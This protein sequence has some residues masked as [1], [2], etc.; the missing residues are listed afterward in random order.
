LLNKAMGELND[1]V[2][3]LEKQVEEDE[4]D[5]LDLLEL[6]TFVAELDVRKS[7]AERF[8][9]VAISG[10]RFYS[11]VSNLTL[12]DEPLKQCPHKLGHLARYLAAARLHRP[13][14]KQAKAGIAA[15]E[16]QVRLSRS[17]LFPDLGLGLS[18]GLSA[19]PE[20]ADQI[21]PYVS[22][23]GNYFHYGAAIVFQWRLD[24]APAVARIAYA[25]AQLQEVMALDRKALGG[26][27]AEVEGAY[28]EV[29]D[30]QKRLAAYRK[31]EGYS[32]KWFVTVQQGIDIGTMED[33]ELLDPAKRYAE[34]RYNVLKATM[35]YNMAMAKLA[36]ATGW[37]AIA[38]GG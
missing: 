24:F 30:W 25:Q 35:E 32:R 38:P 12:A 13:E 3:R 34:H 17:K 10:L 1:E 23:G 11:G 7:E 16:A 6:Q 14:V 21:N 22:D 26:V 2:V 15:R 37:D 29:V 20:V 36:K 33:D 4:A 9:R 27:A 31:A 18:M 8:E 5:P 28:A 19:A